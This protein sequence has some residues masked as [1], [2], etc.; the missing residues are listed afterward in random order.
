MRSSIL[1][2]MSSSYE[3]S[4]LVEEVQ[5]VCAAKLLVMRK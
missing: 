2:K 1:R 3:V 5:T 4:V